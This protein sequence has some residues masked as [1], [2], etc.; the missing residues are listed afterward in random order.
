MFWLQQIFRPPLG[1]YD[2]LI[3]LKKDRCARHHFAVEVDAN[4]SVPKYTSPV[5][6][7]ERQPMPV[8]DFDP[9][10]EYCRELQVGDI[11]RMS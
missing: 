5:E 2:V 6:P 4:T 7:T 11:R 8:Y 1:D 9:V 3:H 10:E